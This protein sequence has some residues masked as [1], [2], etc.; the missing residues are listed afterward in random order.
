MKDYLIR[1]IHCFMLGHN[2][3]FGVI[4]AIMTSQS[5]ETAA[6]RR[7]GKLILKASFCINN[8]FARNWKGRYCTCIAHNSIINI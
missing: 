1:L 4:Y 2:V 6:E 7:V 8:M 3:D 5:G